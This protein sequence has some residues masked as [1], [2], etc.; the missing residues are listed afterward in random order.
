MSLNGKVPRFNPQMQVPFN[1]PSFY[2][3]ASKEV[4][5]LSLELTTEN[6]KKMEDKKFKMFLSQNLH[7]LT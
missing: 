1:Y 3:Y 5:S 6:I 4:T 2:H 7:V